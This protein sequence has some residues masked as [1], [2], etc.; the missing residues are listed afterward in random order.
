MS[1]IDLRLDAVANLY[2]LPAWDCERIAAV[3]EVPVDVVRL[4]L[5][6]RGVEL[7]PVDAR[8]HAKR[9]PLRVT[10]ARNRS[11]GGPR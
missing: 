8:A 1:A 9:T 6:T 4:W 2:A 7:R 11:L 10:N 3:V 5:R